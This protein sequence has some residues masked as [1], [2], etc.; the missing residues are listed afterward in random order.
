MTLTDDIVALRERDLAEPHRI[1]GAHPVDGGV[2]IRAFRPDADGVTAKVEGGSDLVLKRVD[3]PPDE[4]CL[5]SDDDE[6][7]AGLPGAA[8]ET[9]DILGPDP[10]DLS[11]RGASRVARRAEELRYARRA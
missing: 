8:D 6:V 5:R 7:D 3:E 9:L 2:V 4:R 1:L 10:D 11:V